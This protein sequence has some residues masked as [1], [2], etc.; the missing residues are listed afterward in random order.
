MRK[1]RPRE[2]RFIRR[3]EPQGGVR[4]GGGGGMSAFRH[5]QAEQKISLRYGNGPPTLSIGD[6]EFAFTFAAT[7]DG[8]LDLTVDGVTSHIFAVI[9]GHELYL[10]TR[11]GRFDLHWAHPF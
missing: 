4:V 7:G 3:G 10:R 2:L 9:E 6:R 8:G 11:H 5:G 1:R